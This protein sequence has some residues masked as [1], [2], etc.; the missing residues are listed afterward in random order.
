[1][2][3]ITRIIALA[4]KKGIIEG[5]QGHGALLQKL[6][7][8]VEVHQDE[9]RIKCNAVRTGHIDLSTVEK[10]TAFLKDLVAKKDV[11]GYDCTFTLLDG[12]MHNCRPSKGVRMPS[13]AL[14]KLQALSAFVTKG[15]QEEEDSKP[16]FDYSSVLTSLSI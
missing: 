10:A 12:K 13:D 16:R 7:Y 8:E 3:T 1:M 11:L 5:T 2:T 9:L 6:G 14:G 4:N 15:E